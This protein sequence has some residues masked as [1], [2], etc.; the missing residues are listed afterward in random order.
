[1]LMKFEEI[2]IRDRL[3]VSVFSIEIE[4]VGCWIVKFR[5]TGVI[6]NNRFVRVDCFNVWSPVLLLIPFLRSDLTLDSFPFVLTRQGSHPEHR[7]GRFDHLQELCFV[8]A[9]D[10]RRFHA[11][12]R[13]EQRPVEHDWPH[14]SFGFVPLQVVTG[15][16]FTKHSSCGSAV[17]ADSVAK[18]GQS[19]AAESWMAVEETRYFFW[20]DGLYLL[21]LLFVVVTV[22]VSVDTWEPSSNG[23]DYFSYPN[24]TSIF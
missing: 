16:R 2:P 9:H 18:L 11:E 21:Y 23:H 15:M 6:V 8:R 1:M 12:R 17:K 20:W 13:S 5:K 22:L 3:V 14:R 7:S 4:S 10:G 24:I 19:T